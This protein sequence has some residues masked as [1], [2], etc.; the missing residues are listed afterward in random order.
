MWYVNVMCKGALVTSFYESEARS[1]LH[2]LQEIESAMKL[3][4]I[5]TIVGEYHQATIRGSE[6]IYV[7]L[8]NQEV[9]IK[10]SALMNKIGK[11]YSEKIAKELGLEKPVGFTPQGS[12]IET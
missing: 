5:V 3:D 8:A 9:M 10:R 11:E 4:K 2:I 7:E 6:I 12:G 1:A